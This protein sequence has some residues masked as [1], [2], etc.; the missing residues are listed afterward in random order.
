VTAIDQATRWPF[1]LACPIFYLVDV[2]V[3][4]EVEVLMRPSKRKK[5]EQQE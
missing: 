1:S 3:E 2:D 4:V 5:G